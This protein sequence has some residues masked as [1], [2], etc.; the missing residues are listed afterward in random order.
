MNSISNLSDRGWKPISIGIEANTNVL[1]SWNTP[2]NAQ[3]FSNLKLHVELRL[4]HSHMMSF[5]IEYDWLKAI[6]VLNWHWK[7]SIFLRKNEFAPSTHWADWFPSKCS[8]TRNGNI[9][10]DIKLSDVWLDVHAYKVMQPDKLSKFY[11]Q[12]Y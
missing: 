12:F 11:S 5:L 2:S 10:N 7:K 6:I 9:D 8:E 1:D 3:C 4:R